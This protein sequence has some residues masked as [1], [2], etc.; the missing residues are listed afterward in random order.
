M[1]ATHADKALALAMTLLLAALPSPGQA[2]NPGGAADS[3]PM[4]TNELK[5]LAAPI[6][7]YPDPLVAQVL[8]AATFPDQIAVANYWL[9]Q[10]KSLS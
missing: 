7:L 3:V 5:S 1:T 8:S 6:A 4:S 10:H 9:Q 2:I